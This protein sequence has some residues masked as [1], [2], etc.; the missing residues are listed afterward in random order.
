[1][2]RLP[3]SRAASAVLRAL[4]A[5]AGEESDRILLTEVQSTDWQS[6][7]FV[8]EQ[9]QFRFSIRAPGA[10]E[11]M[12]RFAVGLEDAEFDIPGHVVADLSVE[13]APCRSSEELVLFCIHALTIAA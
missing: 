10:Q 8:G 11:L 1:M 6:L 12:N 7:T 4:L 2:N 9:H 13:R 3:M 5:R